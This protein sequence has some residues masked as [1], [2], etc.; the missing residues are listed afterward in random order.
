MNARH[1]AFI[2][3]ALLGL[4]VGCR[5]ED[6]QVPEAGALLL[7]VGLAGGAPMPDELRLSAYDDSG[8]LWSGARFPADGALVP[9][10]SSLLGTIL[11][12]PGTTVGN[13]R[14]DLRGILGAAVVTETIL[15]VSPADRATATF[16]LTLSTALPSDLDGD[17]VPDPIDDCPAVADPAQTGCGQDAGAGGAAGGPD[18]AAGQSGTAGAGGAAGMTGTGGQAGTVDAG[19]SGGT[20]GTTGTGGQAGTVGTGGQAGSAG[21]GGHGGAAGTTGTGGQAG[22]GGAGGGWPQGT[23]CT[24][25]SQCASGFCKD[26]ACCNNACTGACNSCT[27]GT[28]TL[29]DHGQ[30]VPECV[31][32]MSCNKAG[33]CVGN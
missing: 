5:G 28:C 23:S 6:K 26:G 11:L 10:S 3:T 15:I 31:S 19:G 13:L 25:A 27:T 20:A 4:A 16:D 17:G 1:R 22:G 8:A 2:A 12:Q 24:A 30:D 33:K 18:A 7:R 9:Q 14:I 29:V 32:P 21:A